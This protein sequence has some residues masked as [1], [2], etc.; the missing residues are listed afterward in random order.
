MH[1]HTPTLPQTRQGY[2]S[3]SLQGKTTTD[4][5]I[6]STE[7]TALEILKEYLNVYLKMSKEPLTKHARLL[8]FD[9]TIEN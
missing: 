5:Q 4:F 6:T 8:D 1:V 7:K 2:D 3:S 9:K